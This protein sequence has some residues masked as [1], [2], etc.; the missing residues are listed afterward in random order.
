MAGDQ[1][2]YNP[3]TGEFGVVMSNGSIVPVPTNAV[4]QA[5]REELLNK[6][7]KLPK[8][9]SPP[10][11]GAAAESLHQQYGP[12]AARV[13]VPAAIMT[14]AAM[15]PEAMGLP[16][17]AYL[18]PLA[19]GLGN[20]AANKE[21]PQALGGSPNESLTSSFLWGALPQA[22]IGG[23]GR[24]LSSRA[25]SF[26]NQA[27]QEAT[28][29]QAK[30]LQQARTKLGQIARQSH[31]EIG[32]QLRGPLPTAADLR[33]VK[34]IIGPQLP[35]T[36]GDTRMLATSGV[37]DAILDPIGRYRE[38]VGA[39]LGQAYESLKDNPA[40]VDAAD[41]REGAMEI[42]QGL[43]SP[44]SPRAQSL[45]NEARDLGQ[46]PPAE[47]GPTLYGPTGQALPQSQGP[48]FGPVS[49][50][51]LRDFRQRVNGA[52]RSATVGGDKHVLRLL[53]QGIDEQLV[54]YLPANMGEMRGRYK[55]YA[56]M[57]PWRQIGAVGRTPT[58]GAASAWLF[59][60]SP[61]AVA[62]V[63]GRANPAER[64][65][66]K[67]GFATHLLDGVDPNLPVG[68][69]VSQIQQNL[70]KFNQSGIPESLYGRQ[71]V[72]D[73]RNILLTP[74]H[75]AE[76]AQRWAQ[77]LAKR[78]YAQGM[79][80]AW[81]SGTKDERQ[82]AEKGFQRFVSMLP[83][84]EQ[85]IFTRAQIRPGMSY[86]VEI[87]G[88]PSSVS[89]TD[90]GEQAIKNKLLPP[91]SAW[92]SYVRHHLMF[93]APIGLYGLVTQGA[94][95]GMMDM[96]VGLGA[97]LMMSG[98]YRAA[99]KAGLADNLAKVYASPTG[100]QFGRGVFDFLAALGG[101]SGQG[102]TQE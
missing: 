8:V 22:A 46:L 30:E 33:Q 65:V 80:E 101:R 97:S 29:K 74:L 16:A 19:A 92:Q 73:L 45:L 47:P 79:L 55:N 10:D 83:P 62:E 89:P 28:E 91:H 36:T 70:I 57:F 31:G 58:P 66:L 77:P 98:G 6:A 20:I 48:Q 21:L 27:T 81:A 72:G 40:K 61:E 23:A 64:A 71:S 67:Q 5:R 11:L 52:L 44:I 32:E 3:G 56:D 38:E 35:L 102:L 18:E 87:P 59:K 2:R 84:D 82:L 100:R 86:P 1:Y 51:S 13:L 69:Q 60:Q 68:D 25:E 37:Q 4:P 43:R 99:M 49:L 96:L 15:A 42:A 90:I 7:S 93:A 95:G 63:I 54:P 17:A 94:S 12:T 34:N 41:L 9:A 75:R 14:G 50:D 88:R 39:P 26:V 53:Q 24:A 76:W 78:E 85:K